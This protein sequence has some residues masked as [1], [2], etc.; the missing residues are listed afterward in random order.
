MSAR[1]PAAAIAD[2]ELVIETGEL[3]QSW[4][5]TVGYVSP[6]LAAAAVGASLAR[7]P[8][9]GDA[10]AGLLAA[11]ISRAAEAEAV[12]DSLSGARH[13]IVIGSGADRPAARELVLKVEEATW[14]PSAMRDLETFLHGHLPATDEATGLVFILAERRERDARLGRARHALAAAREVGIRAAAILA[15][16]AAA[17]IEPALTPAGRI[18]LPEAP[19]LPTAVAA[20]LGTATSLQVLTERLARAHGTNPDPI[21][22]DDPRYLRAA[23]VS[24]PD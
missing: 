3:D 18:V 12:A 4:C 1:S 7:R 19:A 20:L 24:S 17:A 6:L 14:L 5:H 10:V 16:G 13:L 11:G 21:R 9:D 23:E 8:L 15:E 22:R 2:P